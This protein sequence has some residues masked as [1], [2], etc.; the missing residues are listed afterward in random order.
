M[1]SL[2]SLSDESVLRLP[3]AGPL[4]LPLPFPF[5]FA[6]LP[7]GPP[8]AL[9][10]PAYHS[11]SRLLPWFNPLFPIVGSRV[12]SPTQCNKSILFTSGSSVVAAIQRL[13]GRSPTI[14]RKKLLASHLVDTDQYMVPRQKAIQGEV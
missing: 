4:C 14:Y 12:V 13:K 11:I 6:R 5:A 3:V 8:A 2:F 7:A 10:A 1:Q 9:T